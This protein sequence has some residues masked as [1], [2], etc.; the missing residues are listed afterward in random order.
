MNGAGYDY[1]LALVRP[2]CNVLA[3]GPVGFNSVSVY[4]ASVV[5]V[6]SGRNRSPWRARACMGG[7]DVAGTVA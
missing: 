1:I 5:A 2:V 7:R 4:L 6:S 3:A